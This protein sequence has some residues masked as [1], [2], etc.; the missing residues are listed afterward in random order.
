M[1]GS[2]CRSSLVGFA[3]VIDLCSSPSSASDDSSEEEFYVES[4]RG[5]RGAVDDAKVVVGGRPADKPERGL[6]R[7]GD[8]KGSAS[9]A[10]RARVQG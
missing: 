8:G 5:A 6:R 10:G 4:S 2:P 7:S 3:S 9:K 1:S